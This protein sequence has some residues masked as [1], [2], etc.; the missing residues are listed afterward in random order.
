MQKIT[1]C[2]KL[3]VPYAAELG[4]TCELSTFCGCARGMRETSTACNVGILNPYIIHFNEAFTAPISGPVHP[5]HIILRVSIFL[6]RQGLEKSRKIE[7][8][9]IKQIGPRGQHD[10]YGKKQCAV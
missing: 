6:A 7:F 1:L 5:P 3:A 2:L 8:M 9:K 4:L 10:I